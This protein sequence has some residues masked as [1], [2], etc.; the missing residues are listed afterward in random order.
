MKNVRIG[1]DGDNGDTTKEGSATE[2][3]VQAVSN[4]SEQNP[5]INFL[6]VGNKEAINDYIRKI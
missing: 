3:I 1:I 2:R 5:D 6:L 4:V